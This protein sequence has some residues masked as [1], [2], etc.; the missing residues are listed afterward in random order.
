MSSQKNTKISI[1]KDASDN[2]LFDISKMMKQF[3]ETPVIFLTKNDYSD[4]I[5]NTM[6]AMRSA[7]Q[8]ETKSQIIDI[9]VDFHLNW[10]HVVN[11]IENY[12]KR[13]NDLPR[14]EIYQAISYTID[15]MGY[16]LNYYQ[17]YMNKYKPTLS[18]ELQANLIAEM[19]IV[20]EMHKEITK[21]LL[22]QLKCFRNFSGDEEFRVK[23]S[24]ALED[25]L[26]WIDKITDGL[27]MDLSKYIN[28]N[29]PHLSG[30]LT[31]TLQQIVDDLHTSKSPSAQKML[32]NLRDKGKELGAMIRCTATH[33]LEI[34]KVYEKVNILEDRIQRLEA[35]P[36]SAARMALIHKKEYLENR[37]NDLETL[38]TT[39]KQ[40]QQL[41]D[42]HLE[43]VTDNE[44]CVCEDF[45]QFRIFNHDL[46]PEDREH[47]VTEL[48][49][50][51][52]IAVFGE[53]S[54]K[55]I[56][57]ILSA[58]D[59]KEEYTDELGTFYI[60]QHSRK[61]YKLPDD[62]IHYQ[63]N[64]RGELVPLSDDSEHVYFYDECGRYFVD[65]KTRQR[66]YKAHATASEYMMDSSGILLKVKEE[67]DGVIYYYDNYGR[68]YINSDGKHIYR[69][70]DT[71]SE[72]ENDGFGN[73]VRIRSHLD[74]FDL[75]PGDANVTE[76]FKYLKL[77]VGKALQVCIADVILHQPADPIKYLSAR[78]IKYRE[79][80]EIREKR[81]REK[82]ELD[83]EREIRIAE[84]R[85]E[86]E[87]AAKEAA[88]LLSQ[89]GSEATYDSN[90]YKYNSMHPDDVDSV[91]ASSTH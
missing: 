65:P 59:I 30:D 80:I 23:V 8:E 67:R 50:L 77:N 5:F 21:I 10:L 39:L 48:C 75:C 18:N 4:S 40:M 87:R 46:Q 14:E 12:T 13:L 24:S 90:L 36:T 37:L 26:N 72:Y 83:V 28:I 89:G 56:I 55:S 27:A 88:A 57:S 66:V 15:A 2:F 33:D 49:Y 70:E 22:D 3:Y 82:E 84:E 25:L 42:V 73:L 74:M 45:Y 11:E 85:A 78:L 51:W 20:D 62:E 81:A 76:D 86:V 41:T 79:N 19:E 16:R 68:Y 91:N 43:S 69:D 71:V 58:A 54:H 7:L 29:V 53:R 63:P 31:K 17:K 1:D 6:C 60:D 44:L 47:L 34:C 61:I 52:D 32:E 35:E 9:I 64:E 38:K